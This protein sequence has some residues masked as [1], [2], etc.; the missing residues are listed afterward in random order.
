VR[1]PIEGVLV[2]FGVDSG[3]FRGQCGLIFHRYE[4]L[5]AFPR[6]FD[7]DGGKFSAHSG[8]PARADSGVQR[9]SGTRAAC[10]WKQRLAR[11]SAGRQITIN[12]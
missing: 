2:K 8:V 12:W 3:Q 5:S 11:A 4:W 1:M 10:R 9:R 6:G 7:G